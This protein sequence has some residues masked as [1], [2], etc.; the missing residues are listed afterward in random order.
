MSSLFNSKALVHPS[1]VDPDLV[2]T[3]AQAS[4]F[5][6]A[7]GGGAPR[8]QLRAIDKVVYQSRLDIRHATASSQAS[9]NALPGVTLTAEYAQTATYMFRTRV[10]YNELEVMEAADWHVGLPAAY[11]LGQ[12]QAHFQSMRNACL[13]GV[14]AANSEGLLNVP[15]A[16]AITLP[17]DSYGNTTI[18]NYDAGEIALWF[19]GVILTIQSAVYTLGAPSRLV[20]LGPQRIIGQL[21]LVDVVQLTSFQRSG[22]G[23]A[24]AAQQIKEVAEQMGIEIEWGY[25]DTLIGKGSGSTTNNPVDAVLVT[26]PEAIV[27]ARPGINTNEFATLSPT[28]RAMTLQYADV[29]APIETTTPIPDGVNVDTR[30]RISSGW[31]PRPQAVTVLSIPF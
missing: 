17:P 21:E 16:T 22:G 18:A 29:A 24:T 6:T 8:V 19:Q 28:Q 5:P 4:A 30:Q 23:S 9:Y 25:D 7:L 20:F 14:N 26:I 10:N 13:Y 27:P 3:T 12:R 11:R 15:G 2:I 1:H 31:S